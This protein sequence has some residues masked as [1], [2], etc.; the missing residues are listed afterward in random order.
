MSKESEKYLEK[1]YNDPSH[2]ASYGGIGKLYREVKKEGKYKLSYTQIRNW[3]KSRDEY[4]LHK[5][6]KKHFKRN[7]VMLY[8]VNDIY[9]IDL[10]S[11]ENLA[12]YNNGINFL[13]VVIDDFSKYMS[14]V[15]LKNKTGLEI[16]RGLKIVFRGRSSFAH[17]IRS[18]NGTEFVNKKVSAFLKGKGIKKITTNNTEIK[19][20]FVERSIRTL[21]ARLGRWMTKNQTRSYLKVLQDIVSAYNN[22]YHT[23]IKTTPASVNEQNEGKVWITLFGQKSRIPKIKYKFKPGQFVRIT[24]TRTLFDKE[25]IQGW[26][27]EIFKVYKQIPRDPPVYSIRDLNGVDVKGTFY[28]EEL[29]IIKPPTDEVYNIEKVIKKRKRKKKSEYL[30]RWQGYGPEFDSWVDEKDIKSL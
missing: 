30:V 12:K 23:S 25:Y 8:G 4:T 13:L 6:I 21:R 20:N 2:P 19:A 27:Q 10:M 5:P 29:Q 26:S 22:T 9:D 28:S 17:Y 24:H 14:V 16:V 18:D 15:P 1:I 3:L 11:V 7:K